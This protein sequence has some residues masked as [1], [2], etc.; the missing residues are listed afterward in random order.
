MTLKFENNFD[1]T[2]TSSSNSA[3]YQAAVLSVENFLTS[4]LTT[5]GGDVTLKIN[6]RYDT[7][8]ANGNPFGSNTL[9]NNIFGNN[10]H[11]HS[12]ADRRRSR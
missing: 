11:E 1:S 4:Q 3:A 2:V 5:V 7:K 10:L 8:D 12:Y 6:W 9:A